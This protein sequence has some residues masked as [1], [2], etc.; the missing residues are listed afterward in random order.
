MAFYLYRD[1][2]NQWRWYLMAANHKKIADSGE[3][4][5]NEQDCIHAI[6]LV[7]GTSTTTPVYRT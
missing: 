7:M 1:A 3:S 2:R 6:S 5:Y 4:Y